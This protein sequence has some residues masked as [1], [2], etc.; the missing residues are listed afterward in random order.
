MEFVFDTKV[1]KSYG[2]F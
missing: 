2:F 1:S